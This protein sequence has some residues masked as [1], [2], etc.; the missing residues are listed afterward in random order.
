MHP[1]LSRRSIKRP[2]RITSKFDQTSK[3]FCSPTNVVILIAALEDPKQQ[4]IVNTPIIGRRRK[5]SLEIIDAAIFLNFRLIFFL[6]IS[7]NDS[8]VLECQTVWLESCLSAP[9][10]VVC[11]TGV[12]AFWDSVFHQ[13][14]SWKEIK[15][16][17]NS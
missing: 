5:K 7:P 14:K 16:N 13:N 4:N 9:Y 17:T 8:V 6:S 12:S 10:N 2:L 11:L 3:A 1:G 15:V